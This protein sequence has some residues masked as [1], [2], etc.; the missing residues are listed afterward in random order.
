MRP[1][2]LSLTGFRS[3][4][5]LVTVDFTGK[6]LA[7]ALGDT[8]AG[9]SSLL[10]AITYA[11]FRKSSWDA[12]EPRQLIA[13]GAEAMNVTFTFLHDGH[14]WRVHRAMHATNPN[15]G[16]H[17]LRNLDTGQEEDGAGA[18]DARIRAVLQMGYDTFLRVGLLPQGK[19]DQLLTAAAKER[20]ARL[21]E[22]FGADA[23][24]TVRQVATR[25]RESLKD[26]LA[27]AKVKRGT[28]PDNPTQA[29]AAA[30]AEADAAE[31]SAKRL[32][33]AI[34][35]ITT[36]Q[37]QASS[38]TAA[39]D[40]A[41]G[42]AQSLAENAV[43]DATSILDA[44][45]PVVADI[46]ACRESLDG[47]A[48][49]AAEQ[50]S[51]LTTKIKDAD[52]RG[53][54]RDALVTAATV[55]DKLATLAEDHRGERDRLADL[56]AQLAADAD[57]IAADEE[58]LAQRAEQ[59]EPLIVAAGVAA[60]VSK[61]L[62]AHGVIVRARVAA[63]TAA[64]QQVARAAQASSTAAGN[65]D[66][67]YRAVTP[68]EEETAVAEANLTAAEEQLDA[69][70]L[71]DRA[72]GVAAELHAGDNCPVCRRELPADFEPASGTSAAELRAA[73]ALLRDT[74]TKRDTAAGKL[75]KARLAVTTAETAT[76]ERADEHRTAQQ[77]T[78]RITEEAV[79]LLA[80]FSSLAAEAEEA[81]DTETTSATLTAATAALAALSDDGAPDPEQ[82]I[83]PMMVALAACERAAADRAER[84]RA[85]ELRHTIAIEA[86]RTAV[87]G[88]K[89]THQKAINAAKA[90]SAR[91]TRAVTGTTAEIRA[92]PIRIQTFLPDNAIDV[93]ADAAAAAAAAIAAALAEVQSLLDAREAARTEKNTVLIEQRALDQE[94]RV[95]VDEPL[96]T[97]RGRLD[98]WA[99]AAAQAVAHLPGNN[100]KRVPAAPTE[101]GITDIRTFA[102]ALSTAAAA[103]RSELTTTSA[104][105]SARAGDAHARLKEQAAALADIGGFDPAVDLTDPKL[106]HPLVAAHATASNEA[107]VQRTAQSK[108]QAQV[109]PAA[110]LDFAITAGQARLD[111]LDVLRSELVDAKFLGHLTGLNTRALLGIASD[112]L[113]QLTDQRFGFADSFDIVSR[114]SGV[115]HTPNRLSG[116]EKFLA[117]LALALALAE[118]HSHSGP[119][120]GSLFLDEG[121]AALDTAAMQSALDVLHTQAGGDR[122]VMV[123]SHLHAVAEAVDDVLWVERGAAGSTAR[124]LT[125]AERDELVQ[126]DLASGLQTLAS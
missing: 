7:A 15:A 27:E 124:W 60:D 100:R 89:G 92:L 40:T 105:H 64:A 44:L 109:K 1:M 107:E 121:F 33:T 62:N 90:A 126:A 113:G 13:D 73:K 74:K 49:A 103:L 50:D 16:R 61:R 97:L 31:A 18:V 59:A 4:P 98:A 91:H 116:G 37:S 34:T 65:R 88:R 69:L 17:H 10:D 111:A 12:K 99:N 81:F 96:T 76:S 52:A 41:D 118:L 93:G 42:A 94:T 71:R 77:T 82:L 22:L 8:G 102:T 119:R 47:R 104:A 11:L 6:S 9:K 114:S 19:F 108:A 106:L 115:A 84:L 30:G 117:S 87:N 45:A 36:L 112:L 63:A 48:A 54:G 51:D 20:T 29:A 75:A 3:Y 110:D 39:A 120:L 101:S 123:I 125:P 14:R 70:Q 58:Q 68:L 57:A 66:A 55:V 83:E 122:L 21:R 38:A 56:N 35:A 5:S 85:D 80:D 86:E 24:E 78:Q 32:D 46:S 72:A 95:A 23:L 28:M 25:H 2:E 79:R 53:E 43:P 67:A 26:L